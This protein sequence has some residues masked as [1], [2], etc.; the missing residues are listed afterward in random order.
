[1][2]RNLSDEVSVLGPI[3]KQLRS[4]ELQTN[5]AQFRENLRRAGRCI[6]YEISKAL[7]YV[8]EEVSTPLGS[9]AC[10]VLKEQPVIGTVLRAGLPMH[11]GFLD[12]F[13]AADNAFVGAYR[14][15]GHGSNVKVSLEYAGSPTLDGR[16]LIFCDPMLATA[17]SMLK[18]LEAIEGHGKPKELHVACIIASHA[19]VDIFRRTRP[20]AHLWVAAVDPDLNDRAF[21]V[22][23]L[24][25]AGDLAFGVKR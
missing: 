18:T 20:N 11:Q 8:V 1:M 4:V 7:S 2:Y 17:T 10:K 25:D 22:P 21:I 9:S 23:G 13:D 24:G 16:I 19:G 6:A 5:R 15:E 12:V 3:L 14:H